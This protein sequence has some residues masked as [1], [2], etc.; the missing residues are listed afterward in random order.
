MSVLKPEIYVACL[1]AYNNGILHGEW[2]D[3]N[4]DAE[5]LEMEIKKMLSKSPIPGAEEWAIH[6]H[7]DFGSVTLAEY[8]S[9]EN[10]AEIAAF[11]AEHGELGAVLFANFHDINDAK[12]AIEEEYYGA[13]ENQKEFAY[14]YFDENIKAHF[15]EIIREWSSKDLD[16]FNEMMRYIDYESYQR[17]I[18]ISGFFSLEVEGKTHVFSEF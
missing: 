3:A 8:E 4:Q 13:Y 12:R 14:D 17:D 7:D 11:I 16:Y 1:A 5:D 18:F 6:D 15:E 2:I 9:L 10:V